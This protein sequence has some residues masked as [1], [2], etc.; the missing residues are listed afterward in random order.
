MNNT[1]PSISTDAARTEATKRLLQQI[2]GV[3]VQ[4]R[5]FD[6]SRCLDATALEQVVRNLGRARR[7]FDS[8][9]F[10]V[11]VFGPLKAGKST[12]TNALAGEIVSPA[13]FGKETTRRPSLVIQDKESGIDQYFS[14]DS[15]INDVLSQIEKDPGTAVSKEKKDKAHNAFN[16]VADV[17]RGVSDKDELQGWVDIV[18]TH[19][20]ENNL[21]QTLVDVEGS[22]RV[23]LLT[24]IR[25]KGGEFLTPGVAI[26]DM[27]GLDGARSNWRENPIH[28]WVVDRAEFFFF[29]QS[30]VA[31]FNKETVAFLKDI[32]GQAKKPPVWVIQ[33]L[34]D[35]QHWQPEEKRKK[36]E[37]AQ[38]EDGAKRIRGLLQQAPRAVV[39]L[40]LGMAWDGKSEPSDAWL[41]KSDFPGFEK[42][43][44]RVLHAERASIQECV[45][46]EKMEKVLTGAVGCLSQSKK[47]IKRLRNYHEQMRSKLGAAKKLLDAV[48]YSSD[49][50]SAVKGEICTIAEAAVMPWF[51]S[52]ENEVAKLRE[53][54]NRKRTGKE[55]NA[56]LVNVAVRVAAEGDSKHFAKSL[57]LPKYIEKAN[58]YCESAENKAITGCNEI[59]RELNLVELPASV[60]P[61]AEDLPNL[62]QDSFTADIL[63]ETT[64]IFFDT[65]HEGHT[66][67]A[68]IESAA[69]D[70]RQQIQ[71]RKEGWINQVLTDHFS[72]YCEKRRKHLLAHL[73]RLLADCDTTTKPQEEAAT[74]TENLIGQ[75]D[76]GLRN[77]EFPLANAIASM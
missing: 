44:S 54:H 26:V 24:V 14:T 17:I 62:S 6:F 59:L 45:C 16:K 4:W 55:V 32:V 67:V 23:P 72:T 70:W 74:A 49:W 12:L 7:Q 2:D 43:L 15:D 13:G 37:E 46:L 69:K 22:P 10:F 11:V 34:F 19:L 48:N 30:S 75:M 36:A 41:E 31:T 21:E 68:H 47:D 58:Q 60:T 64:C 51:D 18:S 35:A 71:T 76:A 39:P 28:E 3:L 65:K 20:N 40:N 27:P 42:N 57:L 33:N 66:L 38:R 77:L 73:Q 9:L 61:T 25:S 50:K 63:K 1:T 53:R 29:V 56:E 8:K 52:L 5:K